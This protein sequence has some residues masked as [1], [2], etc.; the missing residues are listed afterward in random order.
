MAGYGFERNHKGERAAATAKG[1]LAMRAA[2]RERMI[3]RSKNRSFA[4]DL[5]V[6]AHSLIRSPGL[7]IA[8]ALTLSLGIGANAA[9][10]PFSRWC[11]ESCSSLRSTATRAG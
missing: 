2:P 9:I 8:V 10:F 1:D 6:A 4:R 11:A 5:R 3:S 7:A